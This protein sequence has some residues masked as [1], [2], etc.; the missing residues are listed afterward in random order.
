VK[1]GTGSIFR[2]ATEDH[3]ARFNDMNASMRDEV[4]YP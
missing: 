2:S 4:S 3:H 1:A